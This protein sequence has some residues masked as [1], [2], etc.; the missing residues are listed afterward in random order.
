VTT[1]GERRSRTAAIL[2]VAALVAVAAAFWFPRWWEMRLYRQTEA[3]TGVGAAVHAGKL[4]DARGKIDPGRRGSDVLAALGNP[5]ER[6]D[7]AGASSHAVW[8]YHYADGTMTVNLTDD[9]VVR[10]SL[11]YGPPLIPTSRRR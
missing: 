4:T 5:S 7:A 8:I 10:V 9:V 6:R 2:A 1:G 3:L 11:A